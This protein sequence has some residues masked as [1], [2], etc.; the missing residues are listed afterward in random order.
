[1][2][3]SNIALILAAGSGRRMGTETPKQFLSLAG[4]PILAYTLEAFQQHPQIDA[5]YVVS[6]ER[7][8][9]TVREIA[10]AYGID[11]LRAV[12]AGGKTRRESSLRGILAL[13]DCC[14]PDDVVLIHDGVRPN[15]S[16]RVICE[17]IALARQEGAC[18]TA[19]E[20]V[21]TVSVSRDGR[22]VDSVPPRRNL[23]SVQTPQSFRYGVILQA[24]TLYEEARAGGEEMPD[25][26]DDA[27]MV[28]HFTA[29]GAL[30]GRVAICRGDAG[31]MKVTRPEDLRIMLS[32]LQHAKEGVRVHD[33]S[34]S[35][36]AEPGCAGADGAAGRGR[37]GASGEHTACPDPG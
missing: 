7:D 17:N 5:I 18:E 32:I 28:L 19:V 8:R 30:T 3:D 25:I 22:F 21:D 20:T 2:A 10:S 27:G 33:V 12:F 35:R 26:T 31:N 14:A 6:P 29:A 9:Q 34:Q 24:H 37:A 36:S 16:A 4:K 11:K 13:R 1:M 15:L 23:W